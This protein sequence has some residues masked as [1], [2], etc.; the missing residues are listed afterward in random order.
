MDS[1]LQVYKD[2]KN[3]VFLAPLAGIT[4]RAFREVCAKNGAGLT[5]SEMVSA[6]GIKYNNKKTYELV[7]ISV[8]E[9]K[10]GIQLFGREPETISDTAL[11][12]EQE[13]GDKIALFDINMGCPATKI[14]NNGEGCALMKEPELACEII[15]SLKRK[16]SLPV[17][18]KFRKGFDD[19]CINAVEFAKR[20]E[21]AGVDAV[22]VHGRTRQQFYEGKADR[23]IIAQV[24]RALCIPVIANGDIFTPEDAKFVL[25]YTG[26]D[27]IMVARGALG[28][29]LIF[30]MITEYLE[31]GSYTPA[32]VE[33]RMRLAIEQCRLACTA[34]GE[35]I[36]VKE[37]RKHACWYLKGI[38]GGAR[39]RDRAVKAERL[40]DLEALFKEAAY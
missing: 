6:K 5:F 36:A 23:Q 24:K 31:T 26:A 8:A 32:C 14:V 12:L 22:T 21:D 33:D 18:A 7:N 40:E 2:A 15:K 34:K 27:G 28:N 25:E 37:L 11:A 20:L 16:V 1:K 39:L 13:Y 30:K 10:A 19:T 38:K 29:P 9:G 4:D 35:H 17:T 3:M